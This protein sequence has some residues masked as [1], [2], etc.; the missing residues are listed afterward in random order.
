LPETEEERRRRLKRR[1][2]PSGV[3]PFG[4]RYGKFMALG[5]P[6]TEEIALRK[7]IGFLRGS[8][9]ATLEL[10]KISGERIPIGKV[11]REFRPGK[12]G[13]DIMQLVQRRE[14]RLGTRMERLEIIRARKGRIKFI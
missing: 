11:S 13:T 7:G 8:L 14:A 6:T 4:R 5:K 3:I 12:K 1:K 10:R 2:K 9:G